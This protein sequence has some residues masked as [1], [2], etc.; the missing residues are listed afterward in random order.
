LKTGSRN[1][2]AVLVLST[3]LFWV[4]TVRGQFAGTESSGGFN[5]SP[6][7][8]ALPPTQASEGEFGDGH[9]NREQSAK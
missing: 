2:L 9:P 7:P 3:G 6:A 8:C 4:G 5:C 1:S